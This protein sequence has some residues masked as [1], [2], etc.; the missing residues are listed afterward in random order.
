MPQSHAVAWIDDHNAQVLQLDAEDHVGT[1][2]IKR[3]I[4]YSR[5]HGSKV[6]SEHEFFEEICDDLS[7]VKTILIAGSDSVLAD[8]RHYVN[9]QRPLIASQICGWETV[10]HPTESDIVKLTRQFFNKQD[11]TLAVPGMN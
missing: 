11:H 9:K 7:G 1:Q 8:F 6:H 5:H 3:H 10:G 4:H 2:E